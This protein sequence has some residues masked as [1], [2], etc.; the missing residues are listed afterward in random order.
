MEMNPVE[1]YHLLS[2]RTVQK[3]REGAQQGGEEGTQE[4]G[5]R[6]HNRR[7]EWK[8]RREE[9]Q[10]YWKS[11]LYLMLLSTGLA[12]VS[13][14]SERTDAIIFAAARDPT[15]ATELK[16]LSSQNPNFHLVKISAGHEKEI[17]A[18]VAEIEK[19]VIWT[20]SLRMLAYRLAR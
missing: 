6:L 7:T 3:A 5:K 4:A 2:L 10:I 11:C 14:L 17:E 20:T 12:L 13:K 18:A 15:N 16:K 19:P 9:A 1:K 8:W